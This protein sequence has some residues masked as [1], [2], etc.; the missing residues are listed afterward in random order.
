VEYSCPRFLTGV[1]QPISTGMMQVGAGGF[2]EHTVSEL[3]SLV[4]KVVSSIVDGKAIYDS[5]FCH[6]ND[7]E[8]ISLKQVPTFN[9]SMPL[10]LPYAVQKW[11]NKVI[12]SMREDAP[13]G[14][15]IAQR[16]QVALKDG[17]QM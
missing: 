2:R 16:I 8:R 11:R 7:Y 14:A 9:L 10:G 17:V 3:A 13:T 6:Y 4:A 12:R 1:F 5:L 15:G